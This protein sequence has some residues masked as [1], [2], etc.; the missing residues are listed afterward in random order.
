[1][2]N[3]VWKVAATLNNYDDAAALKLEL[4]EKHTLVKIKRGYP[5][6][7]RVTVYL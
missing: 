5:N 3:K 2:T 1:M 6:I 4:T 7:F